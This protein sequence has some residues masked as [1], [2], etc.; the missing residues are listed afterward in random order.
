M[1]QENFDQKI[2][3]P[4][5]SLKASPIAM[6][7]IALGTVFILYQFFGA[8]LTFLLFGGLNEANVQN[9]RL[10]T[11]ISQFLFIFIPTLLFARWQE[12]G[13]KEIFKLKAPSLFELALTIIGTLAL[14]NIAQIYLY[15]QDII[16]PIEKL[17]PI[18]E[19]MRKLMERTYSILIS[20]KSPLEFAFV[21]LVVAL[22]PAICEEFFVQRPCPIQLIKSEQLQTWVYHNWGHFCNVSYKPVQLYPFSCAWGLFWL[23]CL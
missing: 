7:L 20:A 4:Q 6:T 18:F 22:T 21:V 8:S 12:I 16:I 15:V 11:L 3:K 19:T 13:Y 2:E 23:P 10:M 17:G 14:Q 9:F 1:E 5:S